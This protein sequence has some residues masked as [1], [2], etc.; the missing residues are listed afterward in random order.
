M[1]VLLDELNTLKMQ[2]QPAVKGVS[3]A[4]GPC[5]RMHGNQLFRATVTRL[6]AV[7]GRLVRLRIL[8]L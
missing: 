2:D 6:A 4:K 8:C 7:L 3:L 1:S 5:A